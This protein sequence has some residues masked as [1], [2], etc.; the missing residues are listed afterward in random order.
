MSATAAATKPLPE[1]Y[2][3][4]T[5]GERFWLSMRCRDHNWSFPQT[6]RDKDW[7]RIYAE[8]T[9]YDSH[10]QCPA[11]GAMRLFNAQTMESGPLFSKD[12][13]QHG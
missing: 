3:L 9:P 4:L 13:K 8:N 1:G 12:V 7:Q 10:Q 6:S 5:V 11:C 2:H